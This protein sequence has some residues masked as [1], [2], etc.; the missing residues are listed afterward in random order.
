MSTARLSH[1]EE[2][3]KNRSRRAE[4]LRK[5]GQKVVG[6]FCC[7]PPLEIMTALDLVPYRIT[8][9]VKEPISKAD[10]YL[11]TIMCP[12][13]R[14]SFDLAIKGRYDFLDG[15]VV[16]H[17]CDTVQR[18]YSIWRDHKNPEYS[19]FINVPHMLQPTS[20][21]FYKEEL[22][23][24]V[25]SLERYACEILSPKRL[26]QE[27]ALYNENRALLRQL[28]N[29][30]KADPPLISGTE[31]TKVMTVT[32]ALPPKEVN[33]LLK[34]IIAEVKKGHNG[35]KKQPA[36][37][38]VYGCEISDATFP[39]LVEKS[40]ANIVIDDL[41]M[42]TRSYWDDVPVTSD[43]L[44]GLAKRY[45][46]IRCPRTYRAK[47]GTHQQDMENR[48]GHI[49]QFIKDFNVNGAVLYIIRYCDTHEMDVPDV[50][51][52]LKGLGL[53]VLHIEDDY[54]VGTIGQLST[55]VQAFLETIG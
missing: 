12:F 33:K 23:L 8:G 30:K 37:L 53:P 27:I 35:P 48:F 16:P 3:Y 47:S 9:D 20:Y 46:E 11:E 13:V 36:R 39:E 45:L 24:F 51:E 22:E 38:L 44:E 29:L 14:S 50:I 26:A 28:A 10:A 41:G 7:H 43:P 2:L 32:T 52:Y 1:L 42:G 54:S 34:E 31:M 21:A 25:E 17:T 18:I 49:G 15:F 6:Y 4:E 19:Y 40:G 55:R 5:Q